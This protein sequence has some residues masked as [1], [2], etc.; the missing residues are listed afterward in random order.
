MAA[1]RS[2]RS[3]WAGL[4]PSQLL[5]HL[6]GLQYLRLILESEEGWGSLCY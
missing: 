6:N 5:I 2:I 1:T 4:R 3:G